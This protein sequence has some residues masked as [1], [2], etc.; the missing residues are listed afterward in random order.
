MTDNEL[1]LAYI[2]PYWKIH[3]KVVFNNPATY[4]KWESLIPVLQKIMADSPGEPE[5][6]QWL[7][8][9]AID[10]RA[11][12]FNLDVLYKEALRYLRAAKST[13]VKRF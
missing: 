4:K 5:S 1:I 7:A 11:S 6:E 2:Q 10:S 9:Y 3:E 12:E 13:E 8:Y